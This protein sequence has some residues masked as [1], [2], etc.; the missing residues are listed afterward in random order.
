MAFAAPAAQEIPPL[1]RVIGRNIVLRP[2]DDHCLVPS[3]VS[4]IA[5]EALVPAGVEYL[6]GTCDYRRPPNEDP[7]SWVPLVGMTVGEAL[8]RL[9]AF[10]PRY[11][12]I[13]SEGVILVR[14]IDAW[15]DEE[16]PL[17]EAIGEFEVAEEPLGVALHRLRARLI[18]TAERA[19]EFPPR[20]PEAARPL[21][22]RLTAA[23]AILALDAIVRAHG[24][25]VWSVEYCK[26]ERRRE[27]T[28]IRLWTTDGSGALTR[29]LEVL[30]RDADGKS[31]DPCRV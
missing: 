5:R 13:E 14:P 7:G 20:T 15:G 24:A 16:H 19:W 17:H 9:V 25:L 23:S 18:G 12:W 28:W 1:E 10:D 30:P 27:H 11:R 26:P 2:A 4:S 3:L 29:L 21:T 22:L 31:Y 6:P 8:E